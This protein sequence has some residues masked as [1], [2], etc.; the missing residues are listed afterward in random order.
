[1]VYLYAGLGVAML[2]GIMAIFEM[3]LA[4]TG[5]SLLPSPQDPYLINTDV[6]D[7]DKRWLNLLGDKDVSGTRSDLCAALKDVYSK[8][9]LEIGEQFPWR[10]NVYASNH[11]SGW[12]RS[13]FM[14]RGVH[15]VIVRPSDPT[16]TGHLAS[17]YSLY[18]CILKSGNDR[19]PFEPTEVEDSP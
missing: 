16:D 7:E 5:N 10:S 8:E 1:M 4:L 14:N 13:C 12:W 3:G 2:A 9:Y 17:K 19:C 18:S 15:R 11:N 6:K